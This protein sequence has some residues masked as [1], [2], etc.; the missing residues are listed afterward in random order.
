MKPFLV[1]ISVVALTATPAVA[2]PDHNP[3]PQVLDVDLTQ[4]CGQPTAG[5]VS[6]YHPTGRTSQVAWRLRLNGAVAATGS[7]TMERSVA[8][9][10]F[11]L[12]AGASGEV[13][14]DAGGNTWRENVNA[15]CDP[16]RVVSVGDSVVWNQGV[17]ADHKFPRRTAELLGEA[18][19]RGYTH[20]DYSISGAVLD[21]PGDDCPGKPLQNVDDDGEMEL[22]EVTAQM[23]DVFCQLD[24]AAADGPVDLVIMNGCINDMDPLLGIPF[25]ITPGTEDVPTAVRRECTGVGAAPENP[26]KDVP[27]FSGAKVG[28]GGRGMRAA[29]ERAHALP[30]HPKVLL[31]DFYYALSRAS[32]R[33]S[34]QCTDRGFAAEVQTE[35]MRRLDLAPQRYEQFTRHSA[36]AYRQAVA[37]ANAASPDGPYAVA[38]D[39][40]FTVDNAVFTENPLVWQFP[41]EDPAAA[42]RHFACPEFSP[43]PPQCLTAALAHPNTAGS[44]QY[45]QN[46]LLNPSLRSWFKLPGE[47]HELTASMSG[48]TVSLRAHGVPGAKYRWFFG[49]GTT[50]VTPVPTTSHTYTTSGPHLPRVVAEAMG[51]RSLQEATT[52]VVIR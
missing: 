45:A 49:D 41:T 42:L 29:V 21:A 44:Q 50:A 2:A 26:A 7:V 3:R 39:G 27:Y 13:L 46:F 12:P 35:C 8:T 40:L 1:A 10:E 22:G 28:Y 6:I 9:A 18:T 17:A 52:P 36:E 47:A 11:S 32:G 25:G 31:V 5:R 24:R 14:V 51:V 34:S 43:T 30:G 19:G 15:G 20:R 38:A 33:L 16:V 4:V 23:P 37:E 48:N